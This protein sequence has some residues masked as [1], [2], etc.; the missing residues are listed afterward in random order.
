M[1][2]TL[3]S[4]ILLLMAAGMMG[5]TDSIMPCTVET[6][7]VDCAIDYGWDSKDGGH[8][9]EMPSMVCNPDYSPL[10]MC[11]DMLSYLEWIPDWLPILD[12]II[13]PDCTELYGPGTEFEGMG[14]CESSWGWF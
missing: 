9:W 14:T 3:L 10:E 11:E 6:Q 7:D 5:C 4:A 2:A 8:D 13:L 1:R 12:W